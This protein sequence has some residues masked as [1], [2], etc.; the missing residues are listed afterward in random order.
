MPTFCRFGSFTYTLRQ[1]YQ[2]HCFY[3]IFCIFAC[4]GGNIIIE[5]YFGGVQSLI[6]QVAAI[7]D[8]GK[9]SCFVWNNFGTAESEVEILVTG[10]SFSQIFYVK[11]FMYVCM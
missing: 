9:Y 7:E 4:T 6:V 1:I 10:E 3:Y 11:G 2:L 8:S 5:N